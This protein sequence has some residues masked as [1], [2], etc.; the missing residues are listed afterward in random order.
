VGAVDFNSC[1]H[2]IEQ[3][4]LF[5]AP[6]ALRKVQLVPWRLLRIERALQIRGKDIWPRA[7]IVCIT[8]TLAQQIA[9]R[10]F[11]VPRSHLAIL[12]HPLERLKIQIL[13]SRN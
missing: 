4:K 6:R 2:T 1:A 12:P 10:P 7:A 13:R 9:R 3:G 11:L 5:A 8:Q